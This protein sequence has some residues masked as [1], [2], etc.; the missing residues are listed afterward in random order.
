MTVL[1]LIKNNTTINLRFFISIYTK[2]YTLCFFIDCEQFW[3]KKPLVYQSIV[4]KCLT[5]TNMQFD[6]FI[7]NFVTQL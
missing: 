5:F 6:L 3:N 7:N 4:L 2:N 1:I